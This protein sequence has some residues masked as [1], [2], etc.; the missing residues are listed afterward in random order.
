MPNLT[1]LDLLCILRELHVLSELHTAI[2]F[3]LGGRLQLSLLLTMFSRSIA[4]VFTTT[5]AFA[6]YRLCYPSI[7]PRVNMVVTVYALVVVSSSYVPYCIRSSYRVP[8]RMFVI[9]LSV[10]VF[11]KSVTQYRCSADAVGTCEPLL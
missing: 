8:K 9:G 2:S 5:S 10:I 6:I 11:C 3:P 1:V 4:F 7:V